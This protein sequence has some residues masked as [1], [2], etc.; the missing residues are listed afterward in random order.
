MDQII[1]N[2]KDYVDEYINNLNQCFKNWGGLKEYDWVFNRIVGDKNADIIVI[3]DENNEAIAGSGVSYRKLKGTGQAEF[4]IGIMTGS[5]TLPNARGKGCFSKM[6]QVSK[7]ICHK[8]NV[9]FLTAFV[10]ESNPSYRRLKDAG[11]FLVPTFHYFSQE[12]VYPSK[13]EA[14]LVNGDEHLYTEIYTKFKKQGVDYLYFDYTDEEFMQQFINRNKKLE[15]LKINN[16]YALIE[17]TDNLIRLHLV[18]YD[19]LDAFES[20]IKAIANW[21]LTNRTKKLFGFSSKEGIFEVLNKL[22]FE[23]LPGFLTVLSSNPDT[24]PNYDAFKAININ[25]GDKM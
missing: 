22:K 17:E 25:M 4:Y 8:N 23:S 11:S 18:T 7:E 24:T 3:N 10:M 12:L 15:V 5:W 13:D 14:V 6:I 20:N 2:P 19:N 21:G 9:P 16:D 1:I